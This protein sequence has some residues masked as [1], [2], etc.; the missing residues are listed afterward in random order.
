M[1]TMLDVLYVNVNH[2]T[3]NRAVSHYSF[4]VALFTR[5]QTIMNWLVANADL[6]A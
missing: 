2:M 3:K 5:N 4:T 1:N 6:R